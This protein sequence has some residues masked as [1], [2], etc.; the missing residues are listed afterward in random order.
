MNITGYVVLDPKGDRPYFSSN[1]PPSTLDR[2]GG[3][4]VFSF[5]VE[6]P[7]PVPLDGTLSAEAKEA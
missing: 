1:P 6:V 4:R 2:S 7:D 5:T 3:V